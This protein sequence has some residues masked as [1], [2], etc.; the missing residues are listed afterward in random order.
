MS[1][2]AIGGSSGEISTYQ[3]V[4]THR[5]WRHTVGRISCL[6]RIPI[7]T[8]AVAAQAGKTLI[9]MPVSIFVSGGNWLFNSKKLTSWSFS[10][11]ARDAMMAGHFIDR[12][13]NSALC[14]IFAPPKRYH[15]LPG[16]FVGTAKIVVLGIHHTSQEGKVMPVD[17]LFNGVFKRRSEYHRQIIQCC[18]KTVADL[19]GRQV[20]RF[21]AG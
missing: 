16:A 6:A 18:S 20:Q 13:V 7:Y 14:V 4:T 2:R 15:S 19:T 10:G 9:K 17:K 12:T 8:L 11:V 3:K 21:P 5:A 1:S